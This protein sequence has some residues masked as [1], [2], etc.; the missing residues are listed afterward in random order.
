[1]KRIGDL[2]KIS[3]RDTRN[4][5]ICRWP[6]DPLFVDACSVKWKESGSRNVSECRRTLQ[7]TAI[8]EA[9][10]PLHSGG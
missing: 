5:I 2:M 10:R 7:A 8:H 9:A 4:E 3:V 1:M 6:R